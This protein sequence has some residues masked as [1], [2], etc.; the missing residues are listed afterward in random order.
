MLELYKRIKTK[1]IELGLSQSELAERVGYSDRTSIAKIESGKTDLP[2][3]KIREFANALGVT[4]AYLMGWDEVDPP[5][6][7]PPGSKF[8]IITESKEMDKLLD[9]YNVLNEIGQHEALIRIEEL[10]YIPKYKKK[11]GQ[12]L[13]AAHAIEGAS[14]E[15]I[16]HDNAIMDDE[17]F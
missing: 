16:D 17:N 8:M 3:S 1:R 12:E 2:Q 4:S 6:L 11:E 7:F 13:K 5:R 10:T 14:Q 9:Y 15:D